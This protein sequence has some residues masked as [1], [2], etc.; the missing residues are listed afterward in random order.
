MRIK[1][2]D[3]VLTDNSNESKKDDYFLSTLMNEEYE[4]LARKKGAKIINA[5]KAFE[6]LEISN[7]LKIVA[8]CGT[9]GKTTTAAAIYSTL[10]DLGFKC[11]LAGTRGFFINDEKIEDKVLTTNPILQNLWQLKLACENNCEFY[12]MEVSSHAIAQNRVDG[13]NFALKVFTNISQDH[14]D[15]HKTMDEYIRVKSSFFLDE[16]LKLIN[17]DESK[18]LY[19]PVNLYRYSLV[20]AADFRIQAYSVKDGIEAIGK[21]RNEEFEIS[22]DLLGEFNLYNL[23]CAFSAVKILTNKL[24]VEI[25]KALSNFGGVA[26]RVELVSQNPKVI[27]DFAHTPDGIEKVLDAL[28]ANDLIIVLGAGGNRDRTKR[29]KMGSI[30]NHYAK[31]LILTSDN[32]RDEEPNEIIKDILLGINEPSKVQVY[33]DRKEAIKQ[34][35]SLAQNEELVVILGKGDEDYQE[36]KGKKYPFSDKEVVKE[37]LAKI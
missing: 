31:Y 8:I 21:F 9:N 36:I 1:Y 30:A 33:L 10:L 16:G 25:S 26:G 15:Y 17:S 24:N 20:E 19:N 6:L 28:K 7:E 14:L 2:K 23:L 12:V 35:L 22:S 34:A 29:P 5:K 32:P 4:E 27:I 18:L 11:A 13:L 3:F 37:I